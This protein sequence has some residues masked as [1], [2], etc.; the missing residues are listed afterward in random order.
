MVGP[1]RQHDG[2]VGG[3][4]LQLE[5]ERPAELLAQG[6][7]ETPVDAAAERRMEDELH[8]AGVV[9]EALQH[10]ALL[11]RHRAEDGAPDGQVVD[12]HGGRLGAD[13]ARLDEPAPGAVGVAGDQGFVHPAAQLRDL[14]GQLGGA[15]RRLAQ[16]ER[17]GRRRIARV[18]DPHHARLH[19]ADLP[20]VAA[21]QEDVAGHRL[22]G[23]VLVDGP[24]ER[25]VGVGHHPV[26]A[27]LGD[28]PARRGRG[29]AGALAGP[30]LA[31]DLV[32]VDVGAAP[33]PARLDA[34]ADQVDHLVELGSG[35][36]AVRRGPAH[37]VEQ[38][39]RLPLLGRHLG[40]DLLGQDVEREAGQLDGVE[41]AGAHRS[42]QGGALHQLVAGQRD[43]AG[44]LAC[45]PGC[46]WNGRP[47]AGTW[48]CCGGNRSGTPARP[49]RC[50]CRAPA[51]QW[52][53]GP[54]GR[55]PAGG[56]RPA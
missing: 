37:Q 55:R 28:G 42:Q 14:L 51:R 44:P 15:G 25:V 45:R 11:R 24:D 2:V 41:P 35:Q 40:H 53:P 39:R 8:A 4:R 49:V 26:V 13:P 36:L 3:G 34:V 1:E 54:A 16:P 10:Q 38:V 23:P 46:D 29:Q 27:G 47:A 7:P 30:Q 22:H 50:R 21:E 52:R 32:V 6:Q 19:P 12:D 17:H 9:E 31:V 18:P 56:F 43:T 20:G 5:V 33:A 48:R